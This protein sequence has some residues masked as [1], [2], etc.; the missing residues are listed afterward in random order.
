MTRFI[1]GA[2]CL[3]GFSLSA[4]APNAFERARHTRYKSA[5]AKIL[6]EKAKVSPC[7]RKG[8]DRSGE[9]SAC[10]PAGRQPSEKSGFADISVVDEDDNAMPG[11]C[12]RVDG[13]VIGP[14]PRSGVPLDPRKA[15]IEVH[16]KDIG[17]ACQQVKINSN[18]ISK[19]VF[20]FFRIPVKV[21]KLSTKVVKVQ[22][23]GTII[24][25]NALE[26]TEVFVDPET[27]AEDAAKDVKAGKPDKRVSKGK[28][29]LKI[30]NLV[31]DTYVV[32]L[33][34]VTSSKDAKPNESSVKPVLCGGVPCKI[35]VTLETCHTVR[36]EARPEGI[37]P[38]PLSKSCK[39]RDKQDDEDG[40]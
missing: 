23:Y 19:V 20:Q 5:A 3:L 29:S 4:T 31:P 12:V 28:G 10:K 13:K 34:E 21:A 9:E 1:V 32:E 22:R 35:N 7:Y 25:A 11:F 36:V 2:V 27:V 17:D 37:K 26:N 18:E 38:T 40:E 15:V 8:A 30:S 39:E 14:A 16:R 24:I 6:Q 33:K